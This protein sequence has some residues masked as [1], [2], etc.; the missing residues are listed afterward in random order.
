MTRDDD[1]PGFLG[2]WSAR[3]R[4]VAAEREQRRPARE[5]AP[6]SVK[7]AA[8][9]EPPVEAPPAVSEEE[10]ADLSDAEICKRL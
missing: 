1:A 5:S 8:R 10:A 9:V 7:E 6:E 4:A 2:R 3:K